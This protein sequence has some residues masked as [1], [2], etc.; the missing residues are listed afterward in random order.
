MFERNMNMKFTIHFSFFCCIDIY[1]N[2]MILQAQ[3]L[4]TYSLLHRSANPS[5]IGDEETEENRTPLHFAVKNNFKNVCIKL[6][7]TARMLT[8]MTKIKTRHIHLP[9]RTEMT[10]SLQFWLEKWRINRK[11]INMIYCSFVDSIFW[12]K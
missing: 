7:I 4:V 6:W 1:I 10:T 11:L 12:Q 2:L 5:A 8:Q 9:S 3:R